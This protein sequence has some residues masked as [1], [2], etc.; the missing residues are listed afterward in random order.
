MPELNTA[1]LLTMLLIV[2]VIF[3]GKK[4][5]ELSRGSVN[6][7]PAHKSPSVVKRKRTV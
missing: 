7:E 4:L 3:G 2:V 1:K 5:L 6:G